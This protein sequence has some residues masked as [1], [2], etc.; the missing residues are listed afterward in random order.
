MVAAT[1]AMRLL[2]TLSISATIE[3]INAHIGLSTTGNL[4]VTILLGTATSYIIAQLD[5]NCTEVALPTNNLGLSQ[6]NYIA[7]GHPN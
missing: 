6:L 3:S 4:T 7:I 5:N 2:D 1:I